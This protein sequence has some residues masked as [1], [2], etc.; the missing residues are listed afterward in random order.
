VTIVIEKLFLWAIVLSYHPVP[1][2]AIL[3]VTAFHC[4]LTENYAIFGCRALNCDYV[5]VKAYFVWLSLPAIPQT[6]YRSRLV[7]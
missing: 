7:S 5:I 6:L 2:L 4:D 1:A 3:L